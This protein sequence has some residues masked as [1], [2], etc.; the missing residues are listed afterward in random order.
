MATM[1]A[2]QQRKQDSG[3]GMESVVENRDT[4]PATGLIEQASQLLTPEEC[5]DIRPALEEAERRVDWHPD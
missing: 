4:V 2:C 1:I 3:S 5:Q